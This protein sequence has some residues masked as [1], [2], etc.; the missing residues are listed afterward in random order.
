LPEI[1]DQL[2]AVEFSLLDQAICGHRN[3]K[4]VP[5][6]T[7]LHD[8]LSKRTLEDSRLDPMKSI[9]EQFNL[10]RVVDNSRYPAFFDLDGFRYIVKIE[11]AK[12]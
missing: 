4:P 9:A 3:I 7:F 1:N 5:Q 11:K 6:E 10:L 8:A 12:F 2:F